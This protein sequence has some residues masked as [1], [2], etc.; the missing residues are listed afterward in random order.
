MQRMLRAEASGQP[1]PRLS[2]LTLQTQAHPPS[3]P[4]PGPLTQL[5]EIER[6]RNKKRGL[7][8]MLGGRP[9]D[10]VA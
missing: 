7:C 8:E 9:W 4:H 5:T 2:E 3:V 6:S 10:A 1:D